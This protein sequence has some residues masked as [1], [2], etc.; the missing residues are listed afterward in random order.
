[1]FFKKYLGTKGLKIETKIAKKK[2]EKSKKSDIRLKSIIYPHTHP[3]P[4]FC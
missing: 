3:L 4:R 2:S 1:M